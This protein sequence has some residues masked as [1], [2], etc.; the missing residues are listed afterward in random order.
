MSSGPAFINNTRQLLTWSEKAAGDGGQRRKQPKKKKDGLRHAESR[1]AGMWKRQ[2]L[3]LFLPSSSD[4]L[5]P[6]FSDL[7]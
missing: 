5:P 7:M 3:D 2:T 6:A 1:K 4:F